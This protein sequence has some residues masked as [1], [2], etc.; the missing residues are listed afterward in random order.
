[1][2][3]K[4]ISS[5]RFRW[6]GVHHFRSIKYH[7]NCFASKVLWSEGTSTPTK[8]RI[9]HRL[10]SVNK[11]VGGIIFCIFRSF[12]R[13][14]TANDPFSSLTQQ[15][16]FLDNFRFILMKRSLYFLFQ[17]VFINHSPFC[18][19]NQ[20]ESQIKFNKHHKISTQCFVIVQSQIKCHLSL[21]FRLWNTFIWMGI[22]AFIW[23]VSVFGKL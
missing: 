14:T 22:I 10:L 12:F 8:N 11:W 7:R 19:A 13:Q 18:C 6:F 15:F 20:Y 3:K 2:N 4:V 17:L 5:L 23:W 9:L 1:M 21:K 16:K